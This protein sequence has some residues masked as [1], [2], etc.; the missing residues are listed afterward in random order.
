MV[1]EVVMLSQYLRNEGM[2][3]SIRSTTLAC[4][5]FESMR[6]I[7]TFDELHNSLEAIY[8]KDVGDRIKFDKAFKKVFN[9]IEI[10]PEKIETNNE[11]QI[12]EI[13][14]SSQQ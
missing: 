13:N 1:E 14:E 8:V 9:K 12:T 7:M 10:K 5:V 11:V 4:K 2:F 3:V 6:N